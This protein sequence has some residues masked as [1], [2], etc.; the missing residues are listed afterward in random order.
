MSRV[1]K[2][3]IQIPNG[4]DVQL[5]GRD[6]AVKG[7]LGALNWTIPSDV[8]MAMADNQ[9]TFE[10]RNQ[11][12]ATIA[13]WGTTRAN[14]AN[15]VQGVSEGFSKK[16]KVIGVGYRAAVQGSVLDVSAGYSHPVKMPIPSG[17]SVQV[18]DNTEIVVSGFDKEQVGQF[19]A[20][21]R[22]V[23]PPEPYKGKGI[24]YVDEQVRMKEGK[25]K[26]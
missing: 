6:I 24:R 26:K 3:P 11:A 25:K 20:N 23:R 5:S 2:S 7:K 12:K 4:V 22:K 19:A 21:V 17:I 1:G 9:L 16:L 15:M 13:L 18:N 8:N 14:V 10:P